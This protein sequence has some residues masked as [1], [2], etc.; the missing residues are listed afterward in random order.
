MAA[1]TVPAVSVLAI[2]KPIQHIPQ[3]MSVEHKMA[4]PPAID[5]AQAINFQPT[6]GKAAITGD[7]VLNAR[8]INP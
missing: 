2:I 6:G 4:I 7:F 1:L 3:A 8:E 5:L